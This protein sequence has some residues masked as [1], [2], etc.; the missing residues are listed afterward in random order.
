MGRDLLEMQRNPREPK[1]RERRNWP[2]DVRTAVCA[3]TSCGWLESSWRHP[4]VSRIYK[5]VAQ[6]RTASCHGG[7]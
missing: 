1:C 6:T 2:F 5:S 7:V 3:R 4:R